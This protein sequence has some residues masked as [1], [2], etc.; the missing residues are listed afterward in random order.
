MS[1]DTAEEESLSPEILIYLAE[2]RSQLHDSFASNALTLLGIQVAVL[3]V[4]FAVASFVASLSVPTLE[5]QRLEWAMIQV[6]VA[7]GFFA[8]SILLSF[9]VYRQA[10]ERQYVWLDSLRDVCYPTFAEEENF[11]HLDGARKEFAKLLHIRSKKIDNRIENITDR[12]APDYDFPPAEKKLRR[13]LGTA[14]SDEHQFRMQL[15][16]SIVCT[17]LAAFLSISG[18]LTVIGRDLLAVGIISVFLAA[19][20]AYTAWLCIDILAVFIHNPVRGI[21][22]II[23]FFWTVASPGLRMIRQSLPGYV[24]NYLSKFYHWLREAIP[25]D[26]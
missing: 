5:G 18:I 15:L 19:V 22:S 8:T 14:W 6:L 3:P 1:K 25:R 9:D 2:S 24:R 13:E 12:I 23:V 10:K 21:S 7:M 11:D 20:L 4:S 16:A 26:Q 17:L